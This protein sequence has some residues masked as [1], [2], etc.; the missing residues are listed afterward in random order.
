[1]LARRTTSS[2]LLYRADAETLL[3][4]VALIR[5]ALL[6]RVEAL[7]LFCNQRIEREYSVISWGWVLA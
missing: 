4:V 3:V 5:V 6:L 2:V 7:A 1:M